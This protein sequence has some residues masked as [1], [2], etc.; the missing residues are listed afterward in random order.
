M[1][2]AGTLLHSY[3]YTEGTATERADY[4]IGSPFS[5][6]CQK[7]IS[8]NGKQTPIKD[9]LICCMEKAAIIVVQDALSFASISVA[10]FSAICKQR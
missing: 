10:A 6:G 1:R 4:C 7:D 2:I 8:S 3:Q 5:K 9:H